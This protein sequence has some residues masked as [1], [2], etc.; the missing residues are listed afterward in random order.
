MAAQIV[1]S[2]ALIDLG[3]SQSSLRFRIKT[4]LAMQALMAAVWR[5]KPKAKV[6]IGSLRTQFEC[7]HEQMWELPR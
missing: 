7:Q 5:R 6:M 4:D 1:I 3:A 2:V